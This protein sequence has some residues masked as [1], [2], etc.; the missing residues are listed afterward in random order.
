MRSSQ[1]RSFALSSTRIVSKLEIDIL[2]AA[3]G[4]DSYGVGLFGGFLPQPPT[5]A[6]DD[7]EALLL[8]YPPIGLVDG[9]SL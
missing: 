5:S 8:G 6:E 7:E 9:R 3:C 2:P 1:K 4:E